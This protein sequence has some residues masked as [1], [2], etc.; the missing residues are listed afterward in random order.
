MD[1]YIKIK[2]AIIRETSGP[3]IIEDAYIQK[4]RNDEV[5]FLHFNY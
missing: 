1:G 3:F 2:S 5:G 4:P